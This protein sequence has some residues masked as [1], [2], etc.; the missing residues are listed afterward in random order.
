M[1]LDDILFLIRCHL[2]TGDVNKYLICCRQ[3]QVIFIIIAFNF[4]MSC[5]TLESHIKV[6]PII[7]LIILSM[8]Y[9]QAL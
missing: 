4:Y 2:E 7:L 5:P 8:E 6:I 3:K 1:L 9:L